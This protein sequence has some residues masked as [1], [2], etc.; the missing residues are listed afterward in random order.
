MALLHFTHYHNLDAAKPCFK[1]ALEM[2]PHNPI[3]LRAAALF[4]LARCDPPR[5]R[6]F[7]KA[8]DMLKEAD[9]RDKD[10]SKFY[11]TEEAFF[12]YEVIMTPPSPSS[13]DEFC[14]AHAND[15]QL[16]KNFEDFEERRVPGGAYAGGGP[17]SSVVKRSM[18]FAKKP[19]WGEWS[20]MKDMAA[21]DDRFQIFWY[22]KFT[23]ITKWDEP[24]WK[25]AWQVRNERSEV[26]KDLGRWNEM[27]DP[28]L[29]QTYFWNKNTNAF[30]IKD[31]FS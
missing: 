4:Q 8:Q 19:E 1:A 21:S 20:K 11:I 5:W 18:V 29:E 10:R 30:Q 7:N 13:F 2:A 15:P 12:H 17:P 23:M 6:T 14:I 25:E 27:Y 9:Q 3:V 26:V 24:N 28:S 31:P 22:N 16:R